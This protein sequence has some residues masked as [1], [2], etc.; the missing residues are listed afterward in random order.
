M[1]R[2][3]RRDSGLS[4]KYG[5]T[6]HCD[7]RWPFAWSLAIRRRCRVPWCSLCGCTNWIP[8]VEGAYPPRPVDKRARRQDSGPAMLPGRS[9]SRLGL[10]QRRLPVSV[11]I[12]AAQVYEE[13]QRL[14]GA[15]PCDALDTWRCLDHRG[16]HWPRR[17]LQWFG[18][19]PAAR[20]RGRRD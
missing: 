14:G 1:P 16:R 6:A 20:R 10:W 15:V 12:L 5:W 19:R 11:S 4:E 18:A 2:S 3:S 17:R 8:A 7:G 9:D 13:Q